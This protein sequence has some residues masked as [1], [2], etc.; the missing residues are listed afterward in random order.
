V[1]LVVGPRL[2]MMPKTR[3]MYLI[4]VIILKMMVGVLGRT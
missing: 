1:L 3:K 4:G 2:T